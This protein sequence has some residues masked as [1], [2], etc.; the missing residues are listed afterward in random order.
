[1]LDKHTRH[2]PWAMEP[3]LNTDWV[4][5]CEPFKYQIEGLTDKTVW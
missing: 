2:V 5:D 4:K 3:D 1:M